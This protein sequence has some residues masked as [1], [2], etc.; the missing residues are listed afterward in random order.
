ML[1]TIIR[2]LGLLFWD[3]LE[4]GRQLKVLLE[5]ILLDILL[6]TLDSFI[7]AFFVRDLIFQLSLLI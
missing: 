1:L 7:A 4:V 5:L 2:Y 6:L 3:C